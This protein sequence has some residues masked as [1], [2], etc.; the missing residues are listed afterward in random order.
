MVARAP[1]LPLLFSEIIHSFYYL[2]ISSLFV[3]HNRY[4]NPYFKVKIETMPS[5]TMYSE[6]MFIHLVTAN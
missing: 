3:T 5:I 1:N 2:F 4:E 6:F